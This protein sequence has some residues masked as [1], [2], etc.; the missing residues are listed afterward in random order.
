MKIYYTV[1]NAAGTKTKQIDRAA[2]EQ[3]RMLMDWQL[4]T[5]GYDPDSISAAC[6]QAENDDA[7]VIA[8]RIR[9]R[10]IA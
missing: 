5:A 1:A 6:R 8:V 9:S 3:L 2:L 10:N 7:A 4:R